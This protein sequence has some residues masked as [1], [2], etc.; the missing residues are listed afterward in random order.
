M[1]VHT[2]VHQHTHSHSRA[3]AKHN[4]VYTRVFNQRMHARTRANKHFTTD[5]HTHTGRPETFTCTCALPH[6]AY[7]SFTFPYL[8]LH[9]NTL[10]SLSNARDR[11][12]SEA[13]I[14]LH[15]LNSCRSTRVWPRTA[16]A[17]H[18][19]AQRITAAL[20]FAA[21]PD[22]GCRVGDSTTTTAAAATA[23]HH[24][25]S[26]P[27]AVSPRSFVRSN[28]ATFRTKYREHCRVLNK[29]RA[30]SAMRQATMAC[31]RIQCL[32]K[33]RCQDAHRNAF[34]VRTR[35]SSIES[36]NNSG[37]IANPSK[38]PRTTTHTDCA[39][40]HNKRASA[41][42]I[43]SLSFTSA[44][45]GERGVKRNKFCPNQRRQCCCNS[46]SI[47]SDAQTV[48]EKRSAM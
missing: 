34:L 13:S 14:H 42:R 21:R 31:I 17:R 10:A 8:H 23:P 38:G 26:S 28:V 4:Y 27:F 46:N 18:A 16:T 15:R 25:P 11:R 9:T 40:L 33:A 2:H 24:P 1:Y 44:R 19:H 12:A 39:W 30:F 41:R 20:L 45:A 35:V 3:R 37:F 32:I 47:S 36:E 6:T 48:L 7:T 43:I 22:P 5:T 29:L